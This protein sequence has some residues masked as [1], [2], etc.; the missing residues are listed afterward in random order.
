M[1]FVFL[2]KQ[3]RKVIF[4]V[5]SKTT[6]LNNSQQRNHKKEQIGCLLGTLKDNAIEWVL[7]KSIVEAR[8]VNCLKQTV[9]RIRSDGYKKCVYPWILHIRE[10]LLVSN[11]L[12][13]N[14]SFFCYHQSI[15]FVSITLP[16]YL[17][18]A[19]LSFKLLY[20]LV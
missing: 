1:I 11:K 3:R 19:I 2:M 16:G 18:P 7:D 14:T 8:S 10:L 12:D 13:T 15:W 9:E 17:S 20:F 5:D 4:T 6:W